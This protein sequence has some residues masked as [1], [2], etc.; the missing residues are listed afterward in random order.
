MI[1]SVSLSSSITKI[2]NG[3][4][5]RANSMV[6]TLYGDVIAPRHQSIWLGSLTLLLAPFGIS[7]RQV[8]TSAFRLTADHWF[9]VTRRGRRSY[10]GL[11][12]DGLQRVRHADKRIYEF[13]AAPWDGDWT[14][15][16]IDAAWK[17]SARQKLRRELLWDGFGQLAPNILAHPR[18]KHQS[19]TEIIAACEAEAHVTLMKA[20]S[21]DAYSRKPLINLMQ[22]TFDLSHIDAAW[23]QFIKRFLSIAQSAQSLSPAEAFYVRTLLIH[24]YRRILLRDPHLPEALLP[25]AWSGLEARQLC[26][27]LYQH[28][29][30]PSE[31]FLI[32]N[33]ETADGVLT[34]TP[35]EIANR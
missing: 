17:L 24:E 33:V 22:Q 20:S 32:A 11:S 9:D 10:Y 6:I 21:I 18:A 1:N 4:T 27:T 31:A 2:K 13:S 35:A 7:S 5:I 19:L 12:P 8:R 14:L 16:F 3:L 26:Q 29:R 25:P 34:G 28:L 15:V 23:T 30:A